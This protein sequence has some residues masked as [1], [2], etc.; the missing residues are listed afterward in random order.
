MQPG[1]DKQV[2]A[3][4]P[5]FVFVCTSGDVA[6]GDA[7]CFKVGPAAKPVLLC[8]SDGQI[9]ALD[10]WC[11]HAFQELAGGTVRAGWIACPAHGA[12]FDLAS[13]E[14]MNPPASAA[15]TTYPVREADGTIAVAI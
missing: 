3:A 1:R 11:S 10:P 7:R 9:F 13:G 5:E 15:I 4:S 14:P 6:D 2:S 12:R 8:R